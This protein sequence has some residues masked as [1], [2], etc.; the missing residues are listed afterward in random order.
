M[1]AK[2]RER[3]VL[4]RGQEAREVAQERQCLSW[5]GGDLAV[6][7]S[8][9]ATRATGSSSCLPQAPAQSPP[10]VDGEGAASGDPQ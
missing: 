8:M 3:L 9:R 5:G 6:T 2:S 10:S 1:E 4:T 7:I